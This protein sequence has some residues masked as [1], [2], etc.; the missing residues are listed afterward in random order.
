MHRPSELIL[1]LA[2]IGC[3]GVE[4]P[5]QTLEP[6]PS[7]PRWLIHGAQHIALSGSGLWGVV[8]LDGLDFAS[9]NTHATTWGANSNRAS[10]FS[11]IHF[12]GLSTARPWQRPGPGTA[13][14]GGAKFNLNMFDEAYWTRTKQ[15]FQDCVNRGIYPV[16]QIWGEP[17]I[18]GNNVDRW[19]VHPFHPDNNI[20]NIPDLPS[21]TTGAD[22]DH[23]FYN[24]NNP[25]LLF[26]QEKF[27]TKALDE[28]AGFPVIWDIGN[29]VGLD[30]GISSSWIQHWA[31]FFDAYE[32][33]HPGVTILSTV[34]TDGDAGHFS[35]VP[36]L[37]VIN[38]HGFSDCDPFTLSGDPVNNANDSRVDVKQRQIALNDH[39]NTFNKLLINTRI[40]S[41]PDRVRSLSDKPG[42]ALETRHIL[43]T[44]FLSAAHFIS[45]REEQGVSWTE[46]PLTTENQQ[47]HLR[48]FIDGFG[49]WK[50]VPR[51]SSIVSGS[52]AIVLAEAGRQYAF[53]APNGDHFGNSFTANL[54][55]AGGT[56]LRG[57]WFNPRDG[58]FG[59][60]FDVTPGPGVVFTLPTDEDWALLLDQPATLGFTDVTATAGVAGPSAFGG[61]GIHFADVTGDGRPDMYVTMIWPSAGDM[62]DLFYRN[63]DGT[64]FPEEGVSRGIDSFDCGS[65]SGVWAD[66]DND[67]DYDLINGPTGCDRMRVYQNDGA[68]N[69][70]DR[71]AGSGLEDLPLGR[72][73]DLAFD[74]DNDGDLDIFGNG[75][76]PNDEDNELYRNNG[77]WTFTRVHNGLTLADGAQGASE[78][79]YDN[80]GDLDLLLCSWTGEN[81]TLRLF[82]ND[83]GISFTNVTNGMFD[84]T[85]DFGKQDGVTWADVDND[86][87]LDIHVQEGDLG[88]QG[89]AWL[90][91]ND[92]DGTFTLAPSVPQGPGFM[93]G[94]EDIDNDGDWDMVYAGGDRIYLN[95]GSGNFTASSTFGLGT[96]N[97][98]R[99]V[100][101]SD[102]DDDGDM[103]L[104]YAQKRTY[105]ML[106]RNDLS[107]G[108]GRDHLNVR[109]ISPAGQA[110]AFGAKVK[111]Y[112][113][114]HAG[115]LAY[116][117]C[118]R[119]ARSQEGYLGQNDPVL[120]F[121]LGQRTA[122]DVEV[123]FLN[124]AVLTQGSVAANQTILLDGRS[125]GG[126][127]D[128][129][130][131]GDV[132]Q[133]DFGYLQRC[134]AGSGGLP[135]MGCEDADLDG[136][137]DVDANDVG[138][139]LECMGGP[140]LPPQCE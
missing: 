95:D 32:A 47:V 124:G 89:N 111:I 69:F 121:G 108:G 135:P 134:L 53:Y 71:T 54:S 65:H 63:A 42:N 57:R 118:F 24:V 27:V 94:F 80:D 87:W 4:A 73:A 9:H 10:L 131:D 62:P 70:T 52:N 59:A 58:G 48:Q 60:P 83:G 112:E 82:R 38:V 33:S 96:I 77:N 21:G 128:F 5:A 49:F 129:D 107:T 127:G 79:D 100:A 14:D 13:N 84:A 106:V 115:E 116:L 119:E 67:G 7:N 1:I 37:K 34:D 3:A 2:A 30:T 76:G 125:P 39:Y 93:A 44:Y 78:G 45:F 35:A 81:K 92:Q 122:V 132:D 91:I 12:Q 90:Y 110:G 43:W 17:Y 55:E 120:H 138:V 64:N 140:N 98:P 117:V 8:Y 15:Y 137:L 133:D 126:V 29:E 11:F 61:H 18:E 74:Y 20:N 101:F 130:L 85:D 102:I 136:D 46:P 113:A 86:G 16:I 6:D 123:T 99:A 51:I 114:G 40:K 75:W 66:L 36:N 19:Y 72:R 109:L 56:T 22:R 31:D 25:T 28:L 88:G 105:N 50:C 26:Y 139:F 103:D 68:G 23:Y 104:F 97:D 41:D